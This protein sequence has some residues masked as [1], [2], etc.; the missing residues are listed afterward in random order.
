VR[1]LA[2]AFVLLPAA[3]AATTKGLSQ[4]VT[5]DI[6]PEGQLSLSFQAQSKQ[7]GNPYE[8][9]GELGFTKWLEAAVTVRRQRP[10]ISFR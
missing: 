8:F 10:S 6:Q 5:P 4:I 2:C 1:A 9:Q 3:A 7:I